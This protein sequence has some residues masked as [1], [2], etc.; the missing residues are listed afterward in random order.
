MRKRRAAKGGVC[1]DRMGS[2]CLALRL[3]FR[4]RHLASCMDTTLYLYFGCH[5]LVYL[6][7]GLDL[8]VSLR[9]VMKSRRISVYLHH[10]SI[11][12][13]FDQQGM[14]NCVKP[15]FCIHSL[16]RPVG[17]V[18][19]SSKI[20]ITDPRLKWH[21]GP[22]GFNHRMTEATMRL[23]RIRYAL[24]CFYV[25]CNSAMHSI[26]V[27]NMNASILYVFSKLRCA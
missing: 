9:F 23:R 1:I 26:V 11:H 3:A 2:V 13:C 20:L 7:M 6:G 24:S 19:L 4:T 27:S 18:L 25:F 21:H 17:I 14:T 5:E 22:Y 16:H 10:L 12:Y 8:Y 15:K